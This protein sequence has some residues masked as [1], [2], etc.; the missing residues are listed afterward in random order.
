MAETPDTRLAAII[1]AVG[2][3][4]CEVAVRFDVTDAEYRRAVA[5]LADVGAHGWQE[6]LMLGNALG[7]SA[8]IDDHHRI[9]D[10]PGTTPNNEGPYYRAGAP[11]RDPPV[12]LCGQDEP[13]DPLWFEGAVRDALDGSPCPGALLDVWQANADGYYEHYDPPAQ[14]PWNLRGRF[15]ADEQGRFAFRSIVPPPYPISR[16]GPVGRLLAAVGRHP[17]RPA[18]IHV[19]VTAAGHRELTTQLFLGNAYLEDDVIGRYKPSLHVAL[20]PDPQAADRGWR[21]SYD[22]EVLP[23]DTAG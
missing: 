12:A 1:G 5:Y 15:Y 20:E 13:G 11:F 23:A 4:L 14:P 2:E 6:I 18:H 7:I 17:F 21:A 3:A 22:L 9:D 10:Q 19:K 16:D 8:A